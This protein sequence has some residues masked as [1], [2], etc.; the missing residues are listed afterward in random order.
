MTKRRPSCALPI[1]MSLIPGNGKLRWK[2]SLRIDVEGNHTIEREDTTMS[3]HT[4][5]TP[6]TLKDAF[7]AIAAQLD[8]MERK[9]GA[10]T[11][12]VSASQLDELI[13]GLQFMVSE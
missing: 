3:E 7:R 10:I 5:S 1:S 13:G 9:W 2:C 12:V 6:D 4:R 8:D 11:L